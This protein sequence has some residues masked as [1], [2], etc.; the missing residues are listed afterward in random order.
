MQFEYAALSSEDE[1]MR[2]KAIDENGEVSLIE[3]EGSDPVDAFVQ[4]IHEVVSCAQANKPSKILSGDLA[5]DA[6]RIC[7]ADAES[8]KNGIRV[9]L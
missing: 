2:L 5:R 8:V 3:L 4:E 7:D 6:I 9:E 1:L